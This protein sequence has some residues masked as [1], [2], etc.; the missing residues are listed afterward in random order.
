M[1]FKQKI[2]WPALGIVILLIKPKPKEKNISKE[3]MG[4]RSAW[5]LQAQ[6][7]VQ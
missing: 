4:S 2:V 1:F 6:L 5:E 3:A 7:V